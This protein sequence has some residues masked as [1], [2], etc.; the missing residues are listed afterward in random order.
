[1]WCET[2]IDKIAGR[3][4]ADMTCIVRTEDTL[5]GKPRVKGTRVGARTLYELHIL[6]QMSLE[7]VADSY[8]HISVED[9]KAA[10]EYMDPAKDQ[11]SP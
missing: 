4:I 6:K 10:V 7:E 3:Y 1:M 5:H 9:V 11:R 8:P 2:V